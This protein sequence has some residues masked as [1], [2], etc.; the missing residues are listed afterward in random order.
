[1][2]GSQTPKRFLRSVVRGGGISGED[3]EKGVNTGK[4]EERRKV[5]YA[6]PKEESILE[7]SS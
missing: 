3:M 4:E 5:R 2:H 6:K 7:H 1:M